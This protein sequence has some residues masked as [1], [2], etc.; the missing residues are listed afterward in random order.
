M[1]TL[2]DITHIQRCIYRTIK[3]KVVNQN[4]MQLHRSVNGPLTS[5]LVF[6]KGLRLSQ[7]LG[8]NPVLKTFVSAKF[9]LKTVFTKDDLAKS[10]II[11]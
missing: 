10:K 2:Q 3:D 6:T 7:V 9:C 1:T 5:G 11:I 4:F 8:L